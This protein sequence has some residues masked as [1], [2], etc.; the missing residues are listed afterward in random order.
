MGKDNQ[1]LADLGSLYTSLEMLMYGR[2]SDKSS[3]IGINAAWEI[4]IIIEDGPYI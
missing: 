2:L 1:A 3:E 4:Q